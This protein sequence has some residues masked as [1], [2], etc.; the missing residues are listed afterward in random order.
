MHTLL[1][2]LFLVKSGSV[3]YKEKPLD[4]SGNLVAYLPIGCPHLMRYRVLKQTRLQKVSE[5]TPFYPWPVHR[6]K[7]G[8]AVSATRIRFY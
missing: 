3:A 6:R 5:F 2:F 4:F 7:P 8:Q 1:V